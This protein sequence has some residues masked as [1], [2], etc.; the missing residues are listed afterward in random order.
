MVLLTRCG[1]T[2]GTGPNA[3]GG[4]GAGLSLVAVAATTVSTAAAATVAPMGTARRGMLLGAGTLPAYDRWS[5]VSRKPALSWRVRSSSV[6]IDVLL[7]GD[8]RGPEAFQG[9]GGL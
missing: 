6:N 3:F 9:A 4:V 8:E 5:V 7:L 2:W 1:F